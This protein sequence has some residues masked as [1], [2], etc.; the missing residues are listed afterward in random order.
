MSK[1]LILLSLL[2]S[3]LT[4]TSCSNPFQTNVSSPTV[5]RLEPTDCDLLSEGF[6]RAAQAHSG[7][8]REA[9]T[10]LARVL[11][12]DAG[13]MAESVAR[14]QL[15]Q[16]VESPNQFFYPEFARIWPKIQDPD[17][18]TSVRDFSRARYLESSWATMTAFCPILETHNLTKY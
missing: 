12:S 3:G 10:D 6:L 7:A 1:R 8:V 13:S 14:V 16:L 17:L 11:D 4:L 18:K 9:E 2:V 15:K 5:A